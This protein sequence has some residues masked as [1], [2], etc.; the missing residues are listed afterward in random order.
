MAQIPST[1]LGNSVRITF[2][3]RDAT[4]ALNNPTNLIV[5]TE[6]PQTHTITT[7][8]YGTNPE[9]TNVSVGNWAFVFLPNEAGEWVV[10]D[11]G[12]GNF[13]VA[14]QIIFNVLPGNI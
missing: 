7:F 3:T 1:L 10:Q 2:T 11:I 8:T 9:I 12:S 14:G 13:N 6:S 5:K 4:G